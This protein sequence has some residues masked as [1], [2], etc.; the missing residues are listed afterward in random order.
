[1]GVYFDHDG[2][3]F[4][5]KSGWISADDA[6]SLT[7]RVLGYDRGRG[8]LIIRDLLIWGAKQGYYTLAA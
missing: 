7:V 6:A 4:A 3:G 1:N 8:R 2:N 5:E